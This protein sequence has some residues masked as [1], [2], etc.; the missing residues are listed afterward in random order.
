MKPETGQTRLGEFMVARGLVSG[1]QVTMALRHQKSTGQVLGQTLCQLGLLTPLALNEVLAQRAGLKTVDLACLRPSPEALR[2]VPA[3]FAL[4]WN[5]LPFAWAEEER[6]LSLVTSTPADLALQDALRHV[7]PS[8]VQIHLFLAPAEELKRALALA[9]EQLKTVDYLL[10]ELEQGVF[11]SAPGAGAEDKVGALVEELIREAVQMGASDVHLAPEASHIR[12][13]YRIDGLLQPIRLLNRNLWQALVVR[14]K[15]MAGMNI[16][17]CRAPQ[18]GRGTVEVWGRMV[19]CRV[20]THPTLHGENLVLR[21]LQRERSVLPLSSLGFT[22]EQE[23]CLLRLLRTPEGLILVTGPTGAGKTSTL[24]GLLQHLDQ[25]RMNIMTLEDPVEHPLPGL[26]QTSV[27][28]AAK[29]DFADGVRAMMRQDPDVI[30]IGEIRDQDTATMAFRA[31][32]T[33]HLV[34]ATLH[35]NSAIGAI[36]RLLGLGL[37]PATMAGNIR[38]ILAQRLVRRLCPACKAPYEA[39]EGEKSLMGVAVEEALTLYGPKG[40]CECSQ[41][42]YGGRMAILEMLTFTPELD[43]ALVHPLPQEELQRRSGS[44][45][46]LLAQGLARVRE[47][48]TSLAE[49]QR[50]V[51]V[52]GY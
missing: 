51:P 33:G 24:Y 5:V 50:V 30:L 27:C 4:R 1:E 10:A 15:V 31:A 49:L 7:L 47:G 35:C 42:G 20:S 21:L 14:V 44:L 25:G 11:R 52:P 32:M 23:A 38:A 6:H 19:D 9:Y 3:E 28:A 26:C 16:T 39:S 13:R 40:C 48:V 8:A 37:S 36:P 46:P 2:L 29:L 18:D 41:R 12:L 45:K 17:E 43:S 22:P 34:L